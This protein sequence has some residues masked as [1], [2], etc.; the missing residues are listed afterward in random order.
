MSITN[1]EIAAQIVELINKWN[2]REDQLVAWLAGSATGGPNG[3]G[4]YPLT[5]ELGVTYLVACPAKMVSVTQ[6]GDPAKTAAVIECFI[7]PPPATVI[8]GYVAPGN[9]NFTNTS[10]VGYARSV[11]TNT[12]VFTMRKTSGGVTTTVGT[13]TF[14]A[15]NATPVFNFTGGQVTLVKGDIFEVVSPTIQDATLSGPSMTFSGV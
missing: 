14:S 1:A 15:G 10:C 13:V 12:A 9:Q 2:N 7:K 6:K 5:N 4:L 3:D 8:G 11:S